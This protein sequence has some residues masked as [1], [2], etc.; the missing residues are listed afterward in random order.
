MHTYLVSGLV[1]HTEAYSCNIT[2]G[3]SVLLHFG[4]GQVAE[5]E[6]MLQSQLGH[7]DQCV[8]NAIVIL[9]AH[10]RYRTKRPA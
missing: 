1:V 9:M 6:Y 4:D 7:A 2:I 10:S 8:V 3:D 5:A